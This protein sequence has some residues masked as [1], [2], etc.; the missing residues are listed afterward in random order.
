MTAGLNPRSAFTLVELL[1][2]VAIIAILMAIVL[3]GAGRMLD[4]SRTTKCS[5]NLRQIGMALNSYADDHNEFYPAVY[6]GTAGDGSSTWIWKMKEYLAMPENSMGSSP[7]PRA[8]GVFICPSFKST[9]PRAVSYALNGY[10]IPASVAWQRRRLVVPQ[11]QTIL[12]VEISRN[13]ETFTPTMV[14]GGDISRRHFGNSANYLY[15]DGHVENT[16]DVI[17]STD[18]RWYFVPATP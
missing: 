16:H 8:A 11:S 5:S 4:R 2:V 9:D 15:C 6:D 10:M 3:P 1:V 17:P 14:G 18:S 12:A 13:M 7:L